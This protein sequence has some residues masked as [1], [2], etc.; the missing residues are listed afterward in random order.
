MNK[1]R[2]NRS[3]WS[4]KSEDKTTLRHLV[5]TITQGDIV[6]DVLERPQIKIWVQG[7]DEG[8]TGVDFSLS[9]ESDSP[10]AS[11]TAVQKDEPGSTI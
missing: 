6:L 5:G 8:Q 4:E 10:L 7:C 1:W 3:T 11:G 9:K 2:E